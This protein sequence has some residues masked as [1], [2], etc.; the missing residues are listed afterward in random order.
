MDTT[1]EQAAIEYGEKLRV[2]I[3]RRNLKQTALAMRKA[4]VLQLEKELEEIG[5]ETR[6]LIDR[7]HK[8]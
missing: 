1:T 5:E 3:A 4:E 2:L 7:R 8:P 6:K